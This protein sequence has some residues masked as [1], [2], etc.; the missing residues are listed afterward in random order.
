MSN[1]SGFL[2]AFAN[3]SPPSGFTDLMS[4][5]TNTSVTV[6]QGS[7]NKGTYNCGYFRLGPLLIQFSE[8]PFT[9]NGGSV[10]N[11]TYPVSFSTIYGVLITNN[12]NGNDIAYT[13]QV[14]LSTTTLYY[15][16]G[17]D[18]TTWVAYGLP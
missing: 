4:N 8:E 17:A 18:N 16:N 7:T 11:F 3:G 9:S 10:Y 1:F 12:G 5:V 2:S 14:P 13:T 15:V 6:Y